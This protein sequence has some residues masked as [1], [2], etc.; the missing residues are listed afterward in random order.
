MDP[1]RWQE[2]SIFKVKPD[3]IHRLSITTD[4]E[5]SL[6]RGENKQWRWLKGN[7]EIDTRTVQ[8]LLNALSSLHAVRWLG[9]TKPQDGF[10]KPQL[11]VAFTTS[12]DNKASRKLIIG[13]PASDGTWCAYVDGRQGTFVISNSDLNTLRLPLVTQ[14]LPMPSPTPSVTP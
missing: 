7:G 5:L 13:A 10:E 11:T 2:L 1:L 3:E 9:A 14:P 12:P 6:E 8:S 4:K